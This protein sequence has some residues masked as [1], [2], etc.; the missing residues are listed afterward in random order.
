VTVITVHRTKWVAGNEKKQGKIILLDAC[1]KQFLHK[2][3]LRNWTTKENLTYRLLCRNINCFVWFHS[4]VP[5]VII[6]IFSLKF[7]CPMFQSLETT[8]PSEATVTTYD[9]N[10]VFHLKFDLVTI[11]SGGNFLRIHSLFFISFSILPL[12]VLS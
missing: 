7:E 8:K 4:S 2:Q 10:A 3:N 1:G 6:T 12:Y 5:F 11:P 9:T